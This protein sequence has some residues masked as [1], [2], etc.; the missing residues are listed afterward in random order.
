MDQTDWM[1]ASKINWSTVKVSHVQNAVQRVTTPVFGEV[2]FKPATV[3]MPKKAPCASASAR[4]SWPDANW[5]LLLSRIPIPN[6]R[7][8]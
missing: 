2:S 4:R 6:L 7:T 1:D 3:S 5:G 8:C